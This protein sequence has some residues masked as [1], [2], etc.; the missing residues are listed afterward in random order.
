MSAHRVEVAHNGPDGIELAHQIKPDV[1][2]CDIG[3]PGMSG[4]EVA[5]VLRADET[6]RSTYLVALTGYTQ[7]D[8]KQRTAE[9]GFDAHIAK[10]TSLKNIEAVLKGLAAT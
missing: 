9:A 10:P 5:R 3:L 1:V 8:D 2:F 7:P 4:F 6:L